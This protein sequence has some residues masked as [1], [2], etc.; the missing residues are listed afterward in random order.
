MRRLWGISAVAR[1]PTADGGTAWFKAVFP[2]FE[3]EVATTRLLDAAFPGA[4]P[5]VIAADQDA[6]WLLLDDAGAEPIGTAATDEQLAAAIRRLV[7]IQAGMAGREEELRAAGV[8]DRPLRRLAEDLSRAMVNPAEIEGPEVA[9][10]RLA[11]VVEW[12]RRQ[13]DWLD[14][15]G[16]P[17]TLVHGDFHAFNVMERDGESVIIDW[18]DSSI[19]HPLLDIGPWFGH[20]LATGDPGSGWAAWLN[21]LSSIGPVHALRAERER[22]FGLASAFQVVSYAAIVR[23]LEP[24]NRYQLSDGVRHFWDLLDARVP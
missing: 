7:R 8:P 14:A 17:E 2:L 22:I 10:E 16:L 12:V 11:T 13:S 15:A 19:S 3:T 23:G 6:G 4:V 24:A 1:V 21:A 9:P 20:P 18:S 5:H